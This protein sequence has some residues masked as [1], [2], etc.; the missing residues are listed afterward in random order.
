M[1]RSLSLAALLA[2][3]LPA[4]AQDE[5]FTVT[6]TERSDLVNAPAIHSG[7][8]AEHDGLWLFVSGRT[9]GLH[10][11]GADAFPREFE[12]GDVV[13]YDRETDTQ[14]SASLDGLPA[15]IAD[16][17]RSTNAQFLARGDSLIVVGGYG[18]SEAAEGKIT[19]G[20]MTVIDVPGLI[21]AVIAA[22]DLAP[23]IRQP[24]AEAEALKVTGGHLVSVGSEL[25]VVGGHRFDGEYGVQFTQEYTQAIRTLDLD[26]ASLR[27]INQVT[28]AQLH[29]RDGNV[30]PSVL[31]GGAIGVGIY[32][33]VFHPETNAAYLRPMLFGTA[34]LTQEDDF[35]Q[36]VG[37]YTSPVLPLY[38]LR[39][40]EMSTVFFGGINAFT[41]DDRT[42][43]WMAVG[44]PPFIPFTDDIGVITRRDGVWGERRLDVRMPE[45]CDSGTG[46][47]T[48][49]RGTN[50]AFFLD[51]ALEHYV[52]GIVAMDAIPAGRTRIGWIVGGIAASSGSFGRTWASERV[53]E[54]T[55][56]KTVTSSTQTGGPLAFELSE[57][58]PN[59]SRGSTRIDLTVASPEAVRAEVF[60]ATGRRIAVL[61][62]GPLAAGTHAL[63]WDARGAAPGL[64]LV[65][66][67][68]G[69]GES[70]SR[71]VVLAR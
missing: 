57:P 46:Q 20:T 66:V 16:P 68:G 67:T 38:S 41:W 26:G 5:T 64:Y 34:G 7:A 51:P 9:N 25:T 31:D 62:D 21:G 40:G 13:V 45:A 71:R 65:R 8:V 56:D 27:G 48:T 22:G 55:L 69:G 33:G 63:T 6:L 58:M 32:G 2:L 49:L 19:F 24:L 23:H 28:D 52:D 11:F 47:C 3:A 39:R 35:V 30:A 70:A 44:N 17:L 43:D 36:H 14:W 53:F 12:N 15:A 50:A 10:S 60:S 42:D 59:P 4:A 61:H 54:V 1:L 18:H 29:R 37:H